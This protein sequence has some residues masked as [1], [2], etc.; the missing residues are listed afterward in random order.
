MKTEVLQFLEQLTDAQHRMIDVLQRKQPLL[1]RP[2]NE[3]LAS[4][5]GEEKIAVSTMQSLVAR[6]EELL[7]S[8]RLNN[9]HSESIE[10]LCAV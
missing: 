6:R 10:T 4:L 3:A 8:A 5:N 1:V 9:L 2:D 7:E